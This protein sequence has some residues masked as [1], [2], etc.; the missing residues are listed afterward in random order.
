MLIFF[1]VLYAQKRGIGESVKCNEKYHQ[2]SMTT[3]RY[4]A[5]TQRKLITTALAHV[6][7][8]VHV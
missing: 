3:L 1:D 8:V 4:L 5:R 6:L 2:K 7:F